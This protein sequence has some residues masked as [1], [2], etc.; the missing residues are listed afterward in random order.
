[1]GGEVVDVSSTGAKTCVVGYATGCKKRVLVHGT[2]GLACVGPQY[3]WSR[4][5]SATYV[6]VQLD[7]RVSLE[8]LPGFRP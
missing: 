5:M 1:M 3:L 8:S 6:H 7:W 2:R 4:M